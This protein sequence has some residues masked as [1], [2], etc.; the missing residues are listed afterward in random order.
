MLGSGADEVARPARE[1]GFDRRLG[2]LL[3]TFVGDALGMPFEGAPPLSAPDP[4]ELVDA[5]MGAGTYTDDTQMAIALAEVLAEAGEPE[6]EPLAAAFLAAYDPMRGYGGGTVS[7]FALWRRGVAPADASRQVFEGGSF[8]NGAAMRVAPV[9]AHFATEPQRVPIEAAR[10]ARVTHA[11]PLG[12]EGA[13]M[14]ACAV[15]AAVRGEDPLEAAAAEAGAEFREALRLVEVAVGE[16]WDP[17]RVAL[18]IG[19]SSSAL[20]SVPAALCAAAR[21]TSFERAC[22]FAVQ[23]GGDADTIAAMAGAVAGARFGA[24]AIPPRWLDGLEDGPRGRT[25]VEQLAHRLWNRPSAAT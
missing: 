21:A 18:T 7:V 6:E 10:S 8:G 13:V 4:L 23:I 11:H 9:G 22:T 12:I 1:P 5:R 25:H 19:S 2:A 20:H 17:E 3:G 15:A 14:Q 16:S 24:S